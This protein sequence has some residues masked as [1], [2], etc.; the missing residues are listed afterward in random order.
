MP[1]REP[2]WKPLERAF[3]ASLA[4]ISHGCLCAVVLTVM[5]GIE[6]YI[7]YLWGGH[8]PRLYGRVPLRWLFDTVDL[9]V[10]LWLGGWGL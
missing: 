10:L 7:G 8:E 9:C 5:W 3:R 2:F 6:I 1:D 4:F